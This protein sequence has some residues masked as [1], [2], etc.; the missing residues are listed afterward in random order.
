MILAQFWPRWLVDI[1]SPQFI[2]LIMA[3]SGLT[4]L[5]A[6]GLTTQLDDAISKYFK[7][8]LVS[9]SVDT[10]LVILASLG[11]IFTLVIVAIILTIIRRTRKAGV[12][13]LTSIVIIVI[14]TMYIKPLVA[15][16]LPPY[17]YEPISRIT[18]NFVIEADSVVPFARGFS[19]PSNHVASITALAYIAGFELN[20]KFG[21]S[22][23]FIWALPMII[24]VS[25]SYLM[26]HHFTDVV[27]GF[28]LGLI[29]SVILSNLM[30]LD[31]PFLM[32]RFHGNDSVA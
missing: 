4:A 11:D 19:Y 26:Q 17:K 14:T 16:P 24:S 9:E 3:F 13:F 30:H 1:H 5:V 12:I 8:L 6:S 29:I 20:R 22:A 28:F 15:R 7:I 23:M 31:Q 18:K 21:R 10:T 32:S 25:R 27:A 2:G